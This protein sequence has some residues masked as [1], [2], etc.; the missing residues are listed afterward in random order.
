MTIRIATWNVEWF[1]GLFDQYNNLMAD[2]APSRRYKIN[3]EDQADAIAYVLERVDADLFVIIEAP[4]TGG[5]QN[6]VAALEKFARA[7]GLRQ[8]RALI[9]FANHTQQEIA[10]LYDPNTVG[11][12]H[13]P[14]ET[15]E[16]PR[17]DRT[18][19]LDV[20][21]DGQPDV[22]SFS[23]PPL[24]MTLTAPLFEQPLSLIGVHAKS[25]APHKARDARHAATL[26]IASRRK[27]LAQCLWLRARIDALLEAGNPVIVL[28]DLNDGPGI[29]H[30]EQLFGKSSV[31]VVLGDPED[32]DLQLY[33]PHASA[34]LNPRQGWSL[35]SARF[36]HR[37]F[38]RYVNALLDY[39]MLSQNLRNR[40]QPVWR[41]WHPFDEPDIYADPPM[42]DALLTAS[43]HFPVSVDLG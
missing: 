10:A 40:H 20:N 15:P 38:R 21:V 8:N 11:L 25:K 36:Y 3:R 31:E 41:I 12:A 23:K 24:E 6:T 32:P 1:A 16:A 29:D 4:N 34:W 35:A 9:G 5:T 14:M 19:A 28:G 27:Q 13:T 42:R 37:D 18:F 39:V 17:F 30:Y 22:H 33:D 2:S 7:Y 43:D 26:A